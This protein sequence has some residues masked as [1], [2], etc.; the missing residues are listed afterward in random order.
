VIV[1]QQELHPDLADAR[2]MQ[3]ILARGAARG[4]LAGLGQM[5]DAPARGLC[6]AQAESA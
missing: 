2:A 3:A 6:S 4:K 5:V 1:N